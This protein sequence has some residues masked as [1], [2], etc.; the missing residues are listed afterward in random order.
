MVDSDQNS[1]P[2]KILWAVGAIALSR[3]ILRI[4]HVTS[5]SFKILTALFSGLRLSVGDAS[6]SFAL[7]SIDRLAGPSKPAS[8]KS[9]V[10]LL[11]LIE[12]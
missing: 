8:T 10:F 3:P 12:G 6:L 11:Q 1:M 4:H 7:Y 5:K 2:T 9:F